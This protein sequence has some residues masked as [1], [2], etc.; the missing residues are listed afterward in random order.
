M[1]TTPFSELNPTNSME[2]D[3]DWLDKHI[4]EHPTVVFILVCVSGGLFFWAYAADYLIPVYGLRGFISML[5]RGLT[6]PLAIPLIAVTGTLVTDTRDH[7]SPMMCCFVALG[8]LLLSFPLLIWRLFITFLIWQPTPEK[9]RA[10]Y[11]LALIVGA[12]SAEAG[13]STVP[14]EVRAARR[15]RIVAAATEART[16]AAR[17]AQLA[18]AITGDDYGSHPV[19]A[20]LQAIRVEAQEMRLEEER[21]VRDHVCDHVCDHVNDATRPIFVSAPPK[22]SRN[23]QPPSLQAIELARAGKWREADVKMREAAETALKGSG[24]S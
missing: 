9:M 1:A 13:T 21:E 5:L 3:D 7:H 12:P 8:T 2:S 22:T 24:G 15:N 20:D 14:L 6:P 16:D 23:Q 4:K 10:I 19:G 11:M 18:A 17:Q